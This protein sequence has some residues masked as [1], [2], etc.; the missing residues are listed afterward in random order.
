MDHLKELCEDLELDPNLE[1]SKVGNYLLPITESLQ[2]EVKNLDPGVYFFS[3]ISPCPKQ[4]KEELFILL[5]KAN[6]FGQGT[7]GAAIG[8]EEKE[9][10]LTLSRDIHYDMDY[11]AYREALEDF[12]N[13]VQYWRD[14]VARHEREAQDGILG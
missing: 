2:I 10:L 5:M 14:E 9:N 7:F 11:R 12:T 1:K 13:I 8:L 3:P 6:L 4:K